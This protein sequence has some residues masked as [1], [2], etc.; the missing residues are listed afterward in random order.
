[1]EHAIEKFQERYGSANH[2]YGA[3]VDSDGY[4]ISHVEGEVG[5]VNP[6]VTPEMLRSGRGGSV[7]E[8]VR[9]STFI[10]NHPSG[11]AFSTTDIR[12]FASSE[13]QGLVA[14]S[15]AGGT[16]RIE[17][18]RGFNSAGLRRLANNMEAQFRMNPPQ[19]SAEYNAQVARLLS[20]NAQRLGYRFTH[21]D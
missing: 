16:W 20:S 2:E 14:T 5:R 7:E 18:A 1:M 8:L 15:N 9:R 10:H 17:R 4:V 21:T 6:Q 19:S 3:L 12:S 13:L 11:S